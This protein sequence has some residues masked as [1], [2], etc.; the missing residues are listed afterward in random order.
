M[1]S[2]AAHNLW[3][4]KRRLVST[5]LA[6]ALGVA[7]L[8]GTLLLSDTLRANFDKL[9][10]QANAGTDVIV[11]SATK[12]SGGAGTGQRTGIDADLLT[13]VRAVPGVAD[14]QPYLEGYGQ[15][16]GR[17]GKVIGGGGPPTRAA[18][19][20]SDPKLNPY[21]LVAGR[22]PSADDEVVINRGAAKSGH[23]SLGTTATLLTPRPVRVRVV[24][25]DLR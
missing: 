20:V 3:A 10:T 16:I 4:Y 8:A 23:L 9:F 2:F 18:N 22:A 7:F 15:L 6:V 1:W 14:A 24:G 17:D 25:S 12:I 11:R 21:R 19:W 13:R 5:V